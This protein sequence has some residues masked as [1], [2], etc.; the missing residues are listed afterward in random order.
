MSN[1]TT[2]SQFS[3]L[4]K[5]PIFQKGVPQ[6]PLSK[7]D[8]EAP[9]NKLLDRG[10]ILP[11]LESIETL[12][13]D[14]S[15]VKKLIALPYYFSITSPEE[16]ILQTIEVAQTI[17]HEELRQWTLWKIAIDLGKKGGIYWVY[18]YVDIMPLEEVNKAEVL[19]TIAIALARSE[20]TSVD[21]NFTTQ[22]LELFQKHGFGIGLSADN[23]GLQASLV[24][25]TIKNSDFRF[26]TIHD[27]AV[28]FVE[29]GEI[30]QALWVMPHLDSEP[31]PRKD[32]VLRNVSIKLAE[33][34]IFS[35][36]LEIAQSIHYSF[37]RS[38]ALHEIA[39]KLAETGD[40][41]RSLAIAQ[42]I[43][44]CTIKASALTKIAAQYNQINQ[45]EQPIVILSQAL[46]IVNQE[47]DNYLDKAE[48]LIEI[49]MVYR[50][51]GKPEEALLILHQSL[52]VFE[53][54]E[55]ERNKLRVSSNKDGWE[56]KLLTMI[57]HEYRGLTQTKLA[58]ELLPKALQ[59]AQNIAPVQ[60]A[61]I[62]NFDIINSKEYSIKISALGNLAWE[63][64]ELSQIEKAT[65]IWSE[66]SYMKSCRLEC[67][68]EQPP[69]PNITLT[70]HW[71]KQP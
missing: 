6:L 18:R 33:V 54:I 22:L 67:F 5:R 11:A 47:I 4:P 65:E 2:F 62:Q 43:E 10:Q 16:H 31:F 30:S 60:H 24:A 48:N 64:H 44:N 20:D 58:L 9:L 63:Y 42:T 35:K 46:Q 38:Q 8:D 71:W 17:K 52:Q 14:S 23:I 69:S 59:Y 12:E 19:M 29:R 45:P 41:T 37:Y 57:I 56:T 27:V 50:D 68:Y 61:P 40:V 36:A 28:I 7:F 32:Y 15:K 34:K 3:N 53:T 1:S 51:A 66:V 25:I 13:D 39:V 55:L 70:N 21:L 26:W 49:A